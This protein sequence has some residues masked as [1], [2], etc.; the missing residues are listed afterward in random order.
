[1]L[2]AAVARVAERGYRLV[3]VDVT[4]ITEEPRLGPHRDAMRAVLG[5]ALSV[6][7]E[8]ISLKGKTNEGMGWIGAGEGLAVIAI[9]T[10]E[11]SAR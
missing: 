1:M 4:V 3:N 6:P 9:A 5:P 8:A 10:V 7:P 2:A 11:E